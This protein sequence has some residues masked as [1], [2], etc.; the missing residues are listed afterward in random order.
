MSYLML[1]FSLRD[2]QARPNARLHVNDLM[3]HIK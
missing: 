1:P 3:L 2:L